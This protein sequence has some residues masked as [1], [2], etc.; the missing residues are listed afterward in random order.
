MAFG[1]SF[2]SI[3]AA[4]RTGADWAW[5]EIYDELAPPLLGYLRARGA[6]EPEDVLGE[7][8][9]QAV[10][11]LPRFNGDEEDLRA[12]IFTIAQHRLLDAQRR[13]ARR[14][15]EPVSDPEP[16]GAAPDAAEEVFERLASD[17]FRQLL[18]TLPAD[19]RDVLLLRLVGDLTVEQVASA[20]GK[21]PG[22]VK[23]LQRRALASARRE[24]QRHGVTL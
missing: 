24:L 12:W 22:A 14:P 13:R 7:T 6:A 10:R 4:A 8:M 5:A 20:I 19:Q 17:R 1:A 23:Q 21:S 2:P 15:A 3:L 18:G 9:L 16:H 11:D